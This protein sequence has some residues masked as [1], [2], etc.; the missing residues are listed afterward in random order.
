MHGDR[1]TVATQTATQVPLT[2]SCWTFFFSHLVLQTQDTSRR[3]IG[4][5]AQAAVTA[6]AGAGARCLYPILP[7]LQLSSF[8]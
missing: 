8:V 3:V 5:M 4:P 7:S 6:L 2:L 1:K